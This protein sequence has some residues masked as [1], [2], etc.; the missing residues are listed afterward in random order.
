M[1]TSE[2]LASTSRSILLSEDASTGRSSPEE[3]PV[4]SACSVGGYKGH[5][6]VLIK[7]LD[8]I[9]KNK[10][11]S[12][13]RDCIKLLTQLEEAFGCSVRSFRLP[14]SVLLAAS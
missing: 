6:T 10:N 12:K 9:V 1:A 7:E 4:M 2:E 11:F 3:V 8:K 14:T 5:I 13:G